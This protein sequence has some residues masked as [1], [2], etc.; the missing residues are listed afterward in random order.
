MYFPTQEGVLKIPVLEIHVESPK[1]GGYKGIK[2]TTKTKIKNLTVKNIPLGY[3][4][5]NWLVATGPQ[6]S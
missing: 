3:D 1:D 6:C 2:R 4:P 5:Q